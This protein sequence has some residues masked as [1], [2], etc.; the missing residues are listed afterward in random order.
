MPLKESGEMYLES[1]YVLCHK[2]P[3][4]RSIDV[5]EYMNYS[6][7]SVSRGVGILKKNG[8]ISVDKD[9]YISLTDAGTSLAHKIFERHTLLT[10]VLISLGVDE[11][12][13]AE[14][15]CRIE[16]VIS[17]A[18]FEAMKSYLEKM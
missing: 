4:V 13:A 10:K 7:P 2:M 3:T 6:K 18:S 14:D 12:T 5:A 16:H 17:E 9:G 1:I 15:A 8:Y 11:V